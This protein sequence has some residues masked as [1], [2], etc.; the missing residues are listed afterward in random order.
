MR[1][2]LE[3]GWGAVTDVIP[4]DIE[5]AMIALGLEEVET[6]AGEI[7]A[8][9]PAHLERVGKIDRNPSFSV[10]ADKGVFNCFSCGY[11]GRFVDLVAYVLGC[12]SGQAVA[13]IRHQ[14]TVA[15]VTRM[16][17][18]QKDEPVRKPVSE[19]VLALYDD[20]PLEELAARGISPEAARKFGILWDSKFQMW[21]TPVRDPSGRL[22]GWQAKRPGF[23]RNKPYGVKKSLTLFGMHLVGRRADTGVLVESPLD[24]AVLSTAGV[25]Y[26]VSSFGAKVSLHQISLLTKFDRVII[27]MDNDHAGWTAAEYVAWELRKRYTSA[28]VV[29]Y[30][31][32]PPGSDPGGYTDAQ[33]NRVLLTREQIK[34]QLLL[35]KPASLMGW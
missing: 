1:R 12:T 2:K 11:K 13:W 35:T 34:D 3:R 33:G 10:H 4:G 31:G 8:R 27:W 20:P 18:S 19:A 24:C 6:V 21:I 7:K 32:L 30:E 16:Y 25:A 5:A 23:V 17:E 15:A 22:M 9:C 14:G 29:T 28:F 26:P